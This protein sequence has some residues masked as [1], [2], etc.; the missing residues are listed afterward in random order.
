ME[1]CHPL[2]VSQ[3]PCSLSR[4][5]QEDTLDRVASPWML[6]HRALYLDF[7]IRDGCQILGITGDS[8]GPD[9]ITFWAAVKYSVHRNAAK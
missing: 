1:S 3:M 4:T 7:S 5:V 6:P 2:G 8:Y 9:A